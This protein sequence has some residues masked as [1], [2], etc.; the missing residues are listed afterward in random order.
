MDNSARQ[1][2]YE[3]LDELCSAQ[4][5]VTHYNERTLLEQCRK[6]QEARE[7]WKIRIVEFVDSL[8][9]GAIT[10]NQSAGT[11]EAG[12]KISGLTINRIG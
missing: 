11:I 10:V 12:S 7:A 5:D 1:R 2:L 8:S 9:S 4:D 6:A 3:L